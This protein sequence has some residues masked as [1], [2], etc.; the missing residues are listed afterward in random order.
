MTYILTSFT[1]EIDCY[2]SL[3]T[4]PDLGELCIKHIVGNFESKT[5]IRWRG[6]RSSLSTSIENP[7]LNDLKQ[8]HKNKVLELLSTEISLK[9]DIRETS[10][11]DN[12]FLF[13]FL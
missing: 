13:I 5:S 8:K 7:I 12:I 11:I 3:A 2:R 1:F 6:P 4:V 9:Q 10:N